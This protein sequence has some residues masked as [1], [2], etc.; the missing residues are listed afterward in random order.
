MGMGLMGTSTISVDIVDVPIDSWLW[1]QL[2]S[3]GPRQDQRHRE[4]D[5][6]NNHRESCQDGAQTYGQGRFRRL[7]SI[8]CL[9]G[10]LSHQSPGSSAGPDSTG[11]SRVPLETGR[12]RMGS[13]VLPGDR[14][15]GWRFC[16]SQT[17]FSAECSP[18]LRGARKT[19]F[20]EDYPLPQLWLRRAMVR[21]SIANT[22]VMHRRNQNALKN[23]GI[24]CI[25][26]GFQT[27]SS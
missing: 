24:G 5:Y 12:A 1:I 2:S 15:A 8:P 6:T 17:R 20:P 4:S 10:C 23:Q 16:F 18:V 13:L 3:H 21:C 27:R 22:R 7:P 11:A 25:G 9:H 26:P 19:A 14:G